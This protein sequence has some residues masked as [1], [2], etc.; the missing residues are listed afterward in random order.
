MVAILLRK[1]T[2]LGLQACW[3]PTLPHDRPSEGQASAWLLPRAGGPGAAAPWWKMME[4][5]GG[6]LFRGEERWQGRIVP[7]REV[8]CGAVGMEPLAVVEDTPSATT[9]TREAF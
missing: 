2:E 4:R 8:E 1:D 5:V 9:V 3:A 7:L 6:P